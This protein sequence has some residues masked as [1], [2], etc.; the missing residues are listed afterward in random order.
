MVGTKLEMFSRR[1]AA[2]GVAQQVFEPDGTTQAPLFDTVVPG[3]RQ[4]RGFLKGFE[5]DR[6]GVSLLFF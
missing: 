3:K 5:G 6:G 4:E 1:N 2:L